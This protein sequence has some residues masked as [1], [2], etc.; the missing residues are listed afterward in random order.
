MEVIHEAPEKSTF[1]PLFEFQSQTPESF[2]STPV[3][4]HQ[5]SSARIVVLQSEL[6]LS[7]AISKL[8]HAGSASAGVDRDSEEDH[9]VVIDDVEVWITSE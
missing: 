2:F 7:P 3:L 4:Y 8:Q 5:T 1:T 6:D 9:E